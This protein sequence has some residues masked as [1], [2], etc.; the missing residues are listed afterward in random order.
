MVP[1]LLSIGW[2]KCTFIDFSILSALISL[3]ICLRKKGNV[4]CGNFV[5]YEISV[6]QFIAIGLNF[7]VL[8]VRCHVSPS[9][10]VDSGSKSD[11]DAGITEPGQG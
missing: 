2:F 3:L 1:G 5:F 6:L 9:L 10:V 4:T 11:A 7:F 8:S